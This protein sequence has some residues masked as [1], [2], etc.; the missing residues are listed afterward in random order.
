MSITYFYPAVEE[1]P[2]TRLSDLNTGDIFRKPGKNQILMMIESDK[3]WSVICLENGKLYSFSE[4]IEVIPLTG[5]LRY[6]N[7]K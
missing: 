2:I 1:I 3:D 4:N 6:S 5:S 7:K